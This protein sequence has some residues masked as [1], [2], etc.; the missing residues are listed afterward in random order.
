MFSIHEIAKKANPGDKI[1]S[2]SWR[3]GMAAEIV[4]I[5]EEGVLLSHPGFPNGT[6]L[7]EFSKHK[8]EWKTWTL[9]AKVT[10]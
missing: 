5:D 8:P 10:K 7:A 4:K 9:F 3:T 6:Y 2:H 1:H